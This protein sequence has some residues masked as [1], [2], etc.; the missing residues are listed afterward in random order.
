MKKTKTILAGI[1]AAGVALSALGSTIS[2]APITSGAEF[3][4]TAPE[5]TDP[6]D[7]IE[8]GDG[9][10]TGQSG[11]LSIDYI[12]NFSF[13][14]A[15]V[16]AEAFTVADTSDKPNVQI[17]DVRGTGEGWNLKLAATPFKTND[18][19]TLSGAILRVKEID[20][21]NPNS[22]VS[23]APV[24]ASVVFEFGQGEGT[25]VEHSILTAAKDSGMG[26]WLGRFYTGAT[27][28][29]EL[30]VPAGAYVGEYTATLT[31]TLENAPA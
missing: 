8:E 4:L 10:E 3:E 27:N 9:I 24:A 1:I 30:E 20:V 23:A 21:Q 13:E 17:T 31:W 18:G 26:T 22:S 7:P 25:G 11:P 16:S 5:V 2:A 28:H 6:V 19:K 15:E 29:V 12:P 14:S